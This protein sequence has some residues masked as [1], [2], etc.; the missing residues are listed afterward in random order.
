MALHITEYE[1]VGFDIY[2]RSIPAPLEPPITDQAMSITGSSTQSSTLNTLTRICRLHT[3][4][5]CYIQVG[6]NPT[7]SSSTRRMVAD[8]TEYIAIPPNVSLKIAV[9]TA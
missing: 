8:S 5:N 6:T 4:A 2:N 1:S 3:T 9:M 7:A